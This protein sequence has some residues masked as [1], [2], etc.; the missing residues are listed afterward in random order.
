MSE[1]TFAIPYR[2]PKYAAPRKKPRFP[3]RRVGLILLILI[4][5]T[6]GIFGIVIARDP[7]DFRIVDGVRVGGLD[8]SGMTPL[9]ASRALKNASGDL[10]E[11][12]PL[13]LELPQET[14]TLEPKEFRLSMDHG[15]AVRDAFRIGRSAPEDQSKAIGLI[16]YL[17]YDENHLQEVLAEYARK[18]DTQYLPSQWTLEGD[19]PD[20]SIQDS[21]PSGVQQTLVLTKGV[22][23]TQLDQDDAKAR[24][25]AFLDNA[26]DAETSGEYRV[27][28][29]SILI[30]TPVETV[31]IPSIYQE[32]YTAP[33]NDSLSLETYQI[34]PG[35]YGYGFDVSSARVAVLHAREGESVSIPMYLEE[36][37][38]IGD[39]VYFRDVLGYCE[40][41]HTNNEDRNHNL[42]KSCAAMDGVILQPGDI[43]SYNETLGERTKENGWKRAGAY[44]G[45]ELVLSYGGGICQGSS[46]IYCAALYADL[47]IVHRVNHGFAVS[48][49][50]HG[51][52]ATVSWNGPDFQFRN[53]THFPI[54]IAAEVS[55]G[56]VKVTLLG[57]E[58]RD[59]YVE[60]ESKASWGDN[61]IYAKSYKCKYDRETGE[62][63]SRELEARSNYKR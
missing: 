10:L 27:R 62:L 23:E 42:V 61:Y 39:A 34:V 4:L 40:T 35:S 20:L 30:P 56:Y 17:K 43:F 21:M 2:T 14:I 48:Y 22:S 55:D 50:P 54:K 16:P 59:Y 18:Y 63:I 57:T 25:L 60:M 7:H 5:L 51:L 11:S 15:S 1:K 8:L 46:T 19:K 29:F 47:E 6:A 28:D 52:D 33:V 44:S 38:I 9:E 41:P 31:D 49:M 36:P 12:V 53:N 13:T 26:F 58:E 24:I 32:V 45:Y 37:E 3:F